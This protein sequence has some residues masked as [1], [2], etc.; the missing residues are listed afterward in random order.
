MFKSIKTKIIN[1]VSLMLFL[2]I[3]GS[4][5]YAYRQSE[6]I[7]SNTLQSEAENSAQKSVETIRLWT[8]EKGKIIQNLSYLESIKSME[9]ERQYNNL[10]LISD[11]DPQIE[12]LFIVEPDGTMKDTNQFETSVAS[13]SYFQQLR[14]I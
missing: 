10:K 1:L 6:K 9:W 12:S 7:L 14:W 5:F 13:Q 3:A 8:E 11:D 4:S 2:L